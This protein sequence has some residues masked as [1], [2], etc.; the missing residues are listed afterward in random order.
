MFKHSITV[1][2]IWLVACSC[3]WWSF[4]ATAVR[5][6]VGAQRN[7]SR[8]RS[9]TGSFRLSVASCDRFLL[10][11]ARQLVSL[12]IT[13]ER[14]RRASNNTET[15]FIYLPISCKVDERITNE[16]VFVNNW[17]QSALLFFPFKPGAHACELWT[18][19]EQWG[20]VHNKARFSY[21]TSLLCCHC[22][23]SESI[24]CRKFTGQVRWC[25]TYLIVPVTWLWQ[26][27][28]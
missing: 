10:V 24:H 11:G 28:T 9:V 18:H 16:V 15:A 26:S 27:C 17:T 6:E 14:T 19:T 12:Q 25:G 21:W 7:C 1:L 20:A 8:G 23:W 22:S 4:R 3:Q 2:S 5:L 13:S